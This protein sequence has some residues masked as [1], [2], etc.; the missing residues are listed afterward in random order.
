M[1]QEELPP[2]PGL[3]P[4]MTPS[5]VSSAESGLSEAAAQAL[6]AR[7][8]WFNGEF[9]EECQRF[10]ARF[11]LQ[12]RE[13][14]FFQRTHEP[15]RWCPPAIQ[16]S[17]WFEQAFVDPLT[18]AAIAVRVHVLVVGFDTTPRLH[19][20]LEAGAPRTASPDAQVRI[21][22]GEMLLTLEP[23][24]TQTTAGTPSHASTRL[25]EVLGR[26]ETDEILATL[27]EPFVP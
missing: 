18:E 22:C 20:Y 17:A 27:T 23:S 8:G 9:R 19:V 21:T 24:E 15:E 16:R 26:V 13:G 14:G 7:T 25:R 1:R 2:P 5:L 12:A 6:E 4:G 11:S 3:S 10:F